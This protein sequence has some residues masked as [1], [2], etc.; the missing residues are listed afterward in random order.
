[1]YYLPTVGGVIGWLVGFKICICHLGHLLGGKNI[2][3]QYL[4]DNYDMSV[5][6]GRRWILIV[7]T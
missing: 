4:E 6:K 3:H 5:Y 1:M 7:G 2:I